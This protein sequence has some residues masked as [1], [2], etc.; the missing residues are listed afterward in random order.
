M[1]DLCLGLGIIASCIAALMTV[2]AL[3]DSST[4]DQVTALKNWA[5]EYALEQQRSSKFQLRAYEEMPSDQLVKLLRSPWEEKRA[6]LR[7]EISGMADA[8]Q[9]WN[10]TMTEDDQQ[11]LQLFRENLHN[12][13]HCE[14][15]IYQSLLWFEAN[16]MT[17]SR[18]AY[19]VYI[20]GFENLESQMEVFV[21]VEAVKPLDCMSE[22]GSNA[23]VLYL[24]T[25]GVQSDAED[26]AELYGGPTGPGDWPDFPELWVNFGLSDGSEPL[27]YNFV[28]GYVRNWDRTTGQILRNHLQWMVSGWDVSWA[29]YHQILD[30]EGLDAA[31]EA[32]RDNLSVVSDSY[33]IEFRDRG[34]QNGVAVYRTEYGVMQMIKKWRINS[35]CTSVAEADGEMD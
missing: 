32:F 13:R 12:G 29:I 18:E 34:E 14:A 5:V 35:R 3:A 28:R 19:E 23:T 20:K 24:T 25:E 8:D 26:V 27:G 4:Q 21:A 9:I 30:K 17:A 15:W 31:K 7:D 6:A 10:Q 2:N 16:Q 11:L 33:Y 22:D 1:R